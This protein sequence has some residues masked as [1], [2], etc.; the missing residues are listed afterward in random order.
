[1][2]FWKDRSPKNKTKN[3]TMIDDLYLDICEQTTTLGSQLHLCFHSCPVIEV[4]DNSNDVIMLSILWR[5]S[6]WC[7]LIRALFPVEDLSPPVFTAKWPSK[8]AN[9]WSPISLMVESIFAVDNVPP[10]ANLCLEHMRNYFRFLKWSRQIM[11][12]RN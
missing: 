10:D 12:D 2:E 3:K 8:V 1:M 4:S 6:F 9:R 11:F 7:S 5:N